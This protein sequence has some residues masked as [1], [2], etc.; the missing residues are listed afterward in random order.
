MNSFELNKIAGAALAAGLFIFGGRT[1]ADIV[2]HKPAPVMPGFNIPVS[3]TTKG[4]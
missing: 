3:L 1:L 4:V 2:L